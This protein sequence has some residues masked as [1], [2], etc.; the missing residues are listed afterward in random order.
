MRRGGIIYIQ[1][2][3]AARRAPSITNTHTHMR[4]YLLTLLVLLL[5]APAA[6]ATQDR[7]T[8]T[9]A[10][11]LEAHYAESSVA[12]DTLYLAGPVNSADLV[13]L[14][15][16]K[17]AM[18]RLKY[19]DMSDVTLACDDGQYASYVTAPEAGMG[20]VTTTIY[21]LSDKDSIAG[22][23]PRPNTNYVYYYVNDLSYLF[24]RHA[25]L[26]ELYLPKSLTRVGESICASVTTL[27]RVVIGEQAKSIGSYAFYGCGQLAHANLPAGLEAIRTNAFAGCAPLGDLTIPAN[28]REIGYHAFEATS[29][30]GAHQADNTRDGIIYIGRFAYQALLSCPKSVDI[31]NGTEM[32]CEGLFDGRS[33]VTSVT[34]PPTLRRIGE[35]A[36]YESGVTQISLPEGVERIGDE[37]FSYSQLASIELPTSLKHIGECA[38]SY[39]PLTSVTVPA[40]VE[41]VGV[42]AFSG[43]SSLASVAWQATDARLGTTRPHIGYTDYT[44]YGPFTL[45]N[46]LTQFAIGDGVR[47]LPAKLLYSAGSDANLDIAVPATVEHI[48]GLAFST[49]ALRSLTLPEGLAATGDSICYGASNLATLRLPATLRSIGNGAFDGCAGLRGDLV[50]PDAIESIGDWAFH[51]CVE[52]SIPKLPASLRRLGEYAFNGCTGLKSIALPDALSDI[53]TSAF[54][55]CSN[56][57]VSHW[58]AALRHIGADAF[59]NCTSLRSVRPAEGLETIGRTAFSYCTSMQEIVLPASLRHVGQYAFHCYSEQSPFDVTCLALTPPATDGHILYRMNYRLHVFADARGAYEADPY[60]NFA[61]HVEALDLEMQSYHNFTPYYIFAE[62]PATADTIMWDTYFALPNVEGNGAPEGSN[63]FLLNSGATPASLAALS[64]LRPGYDPMPEGFRGMIFRVPGGNV[65]LDITAGTPSHPLYIRFG[66][67]EPEKFEQPMGGTAAYKRYLPKISYIYVYSLADAAPAPAFPATGP[68]DIAQLPD[69]VWINSLQI[70]SDA[71][72]VHE[73]ELPDTL[74]PVEGYYTPDGRR[75]SHPQRGV[76]IVRRTDGSSQKVLVK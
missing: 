32:L 33:D 3:R 28:I 39:A 18:S 62:H 2:V 48:G 20:D 43:C 14:R 45:T 16:G 66:D 52:V 69:A 37:A 9:A 46:A 67:G 68:V 5:A 19:L 70:S 59:G 72:G 44:D 25:T 26:Q 7:V 73:P 50:L 23:S 10:G 34:L 27:R 51:S 71:S 64:G 15:S 60:W 4:H 22:R 63:V 13:F 41:F 58:P 29:W 61:E 42:G 12:V 47:S 8:L 65:E 35:R 40:S 74:A 57:D 11:T 36:F 30:L 55:G 56:L 38:F 53:A 75:Y 1:K 24:D 49:T 6:R 17:G 54:A 21:Y 76:N 31:E